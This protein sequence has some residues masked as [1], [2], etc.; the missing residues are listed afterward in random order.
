[1]VRLPHIHLIG[2]CYD[3]RGLK[4]FSLLRK[5]NFRVVRRILWDGI[6]HPAIYQLKFL[7][8][9]CLFKGKGLFFTSLYNLQLRQFLLNGRRIQVRIIGQRNGEARH[10]IFA[11]SLFKFYTRRIVG[12]FKNHFFANGFS[13]ALFLVDDD[14]LVACIRSIGALQLFHGKVVGNRVRN[15][16]FVEQEI[17]PFTIFLGVNVHVQR[18]RHLRRDHDLLFG[19]FHNRL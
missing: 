5:F 8:L 14:V 4:V 11:F 3:R 13:L 7:R 10:F 17:F 19:L 2:L 12:I 16:L 6:K 1:M 15:I 9:I 18:P